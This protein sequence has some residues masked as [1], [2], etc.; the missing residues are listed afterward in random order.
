MLAFLEHGT[1]NMAVLQN[2]RD[3]K[4]TLIPR[5]R[6]TQ[7]EALVEWEDEMHE[8]ERDKEVQKIWIF[9]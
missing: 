8:R 2:L 6:P 7:F 5:P 1:F 9:L 3:K 4:M